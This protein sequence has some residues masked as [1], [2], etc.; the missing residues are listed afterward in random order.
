MKPYPLLDLRSVLCLLVIVALVISVPVIM[1][2]QE[3]PKLKKTTAPSTSPASGAEMYKAYCAVCHG[4]TGKGD[5]P[6]APALKAHLSDLTTLA[7]RN[8]GQF[9]SLK[10]KSILEGKD[11]VVAHGSKEMPVWGPVFLGLTPNRD[12]TMVT[13]RVTNLTNYLESIQTK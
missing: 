5:G 6:A 3:T 1:S 8:N 10:V 2:G 7:Q 9:P 13:M 11:S 12:R 4:V